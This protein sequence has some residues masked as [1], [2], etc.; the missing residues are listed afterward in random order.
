MV[1][2]KSEMSCYHGVMEKKHV[3]L[4]ERLRKQPLCKDYIKAAGGLMYGLAYERTVG[5]N[6]AMVEIRKEDLKK[7]ETARVSVVGNNTLQNKFREEVCGECL[8][9]RWMVN[10]ESLSGGE[11]GWEF[12]SNYF[13]HNV[14][15]DLDK[16]LCRDLKNKG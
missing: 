16:M 6:V 8:Y 7:K 2:E 13:S 4:E 11:Y 1:F 12:R 10:R 5:E 15:A 9:H 3:S 14:R